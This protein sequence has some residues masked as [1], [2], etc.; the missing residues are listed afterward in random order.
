MGPFPYAS[1]AQN[2]PRAL[3]WRLEEHAL[4]QNTLPPESNYR[5][6]MTTAELA[7][8]RTVPFVG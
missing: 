8:M 7:A 6:R 3:T 5:S 1:S 4:R 2:P